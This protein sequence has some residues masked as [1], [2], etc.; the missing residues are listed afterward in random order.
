MDLMI[1]DSVVIQ[2]SDYPSR[3]IRAAG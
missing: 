2:A 3:F 1:N